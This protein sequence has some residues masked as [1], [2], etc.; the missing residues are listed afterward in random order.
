MK[1]L[2]VKLNDSGQ[3][4]DKFLEKTFPHMPKSLMYKEI[5]KKNIKVNGKR[6]EISYRIQV[7]DTINLFVNDELLVKDFNAISEFIKIFP[8]FA[9][10]DEN[11]A[12]IKKP[13]GLLSQEDENGVGD[14]AENRFRAYLV[15]IGEYDTTI[16]NSFM[17]SL[18]NRLDRNTE[19]ILIAAKNAEALRILNEKIKNREIEKR[20]ICVLSGVPEKKHA[21]LKAYHFKNEKSKKVAI[22]DIPAPG[23]KEIITE[24]TI[25]RDNG[26]LSLAEILLHTGRTHQIRAHMAYVGFPLVGDSKYGDFPLNRELGVKSQLLCAY[27]LKFAFRGDAG[28]LNYLKDKEFELK[29]PDSYL[30]ISE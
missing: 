14:T 2:L 24:Y 4:L 11:I 30:K 20:Y 27:K 22:F 16:E 1:E 13:V 10:E 7:N 25:L 21:V 17:P 23:R 6:A 5:R 15:K 18:C 19:G 29:I 3:R 9:Y 8:V 12:I 26:R 28:I